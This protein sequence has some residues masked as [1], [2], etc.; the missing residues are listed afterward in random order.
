MGI[1]AGVCVLTST[2]RPSDGDAGL[3]TG[4]GTATRAQPHRRAAALPACAQ[5]AHTDSEDIQ[6]QLLA[7]TVPLSNGSVASQLLASCFQFF[8]S[9]PSFVSSTL[10]DACFRSIPENLRANRGWRGETSLATSPPYTSG[11]MLRKRE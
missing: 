6:P 7:A 5:L 4:T 10:A 9:P 11:R 3:F 1:A 8:F 2:D